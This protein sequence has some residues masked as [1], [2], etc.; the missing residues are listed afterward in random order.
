MHIAI[1]HGYLLEGTGSNLFVQNLCREF[2]RLGHHV[3]LFCQEMA[4]QDFDFIADAFEFPPL[5]TQPTLQWERE[6]PYTGKCEFYRPH[7]GGLL[8]VYVYD[9]YEGFTVKE[10]PDLTPQEIEGYIE[11][12][13]RALTSVFSRRRPDL[14][15]SQHTIMQ[16]VYAARALR[17]LDPCRHYM[18]VHGSCLN[19]SVRRSA[20]LQDYASEAVSA[21]DRIICASEAARKELIDFFADDRTIEGRPAVITMG[22][23]VD[24]FRPLAPGEKKVSRVE[25]LIES[26]STGEG[27]GSFISSEKRLLS[28]AVADAANVSDLAQE[29]ASARKNLAGSEGDPDVAQRLY[30]IDWDRDPVII[31]HGKFLWTKGAHLLL[32]A[33]PL[34]LLRH[35]T[36][37][38]ILVGFGSQRAFLEAL[39]A[40]LEF[41]RRELFMEMLSRPDVL[42]PEADPGSSRYFAALLDRIANRSAAD[43][44]FS[45]AQ[46]SLLDRVIFTGY[47]DHNRLKNLLPCAEIAVAPSIFPEAFGLVAIEALASGVIPLLANHS[48]LTTVIREVVE[49]FSDTFD[50]ARFKPLFLDEELVINLAG[51]ISTFLDYYS[52][53]DTEDRQSIRSRARDIA[54]AK[55]SWDAV[56]RSYLAL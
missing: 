4:P 18:T 14:V 55:Y 50:E 12:N 53:M 1:V 34:I 54:L 17:D 16:P 37:R 51:N 33:A 43:D 29:L 28:R 32:A 42:D 23:D 6:T 19:F 46:G 49:E 25:Q 5:N 47:L 2:C 8:P 36:A 27:G 45:S 9:H 21:C 44:Y 20:L 40:A 7:L 52:E 11:H 13:R 56:A 30:S 15:L 48:S 39:A 22:V 38:F 26:L 41:G 35:P 10:Y 31:F 3:S 24:K